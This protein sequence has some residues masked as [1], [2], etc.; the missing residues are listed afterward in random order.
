MY[1]GG[2]D[3][4]TLLSDSATKPSYSKEVQHLGNEIRE[5]V[6]LFSSSFTAVQSYVRRLLDSPDFI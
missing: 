4:M 2:H 6:D 3:P 1:L 5:A